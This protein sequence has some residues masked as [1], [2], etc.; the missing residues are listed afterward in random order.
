MYNLDVFGNDNFF[1]GEG[2]WLVH[3]A[4]YAAL[5][6]TLKSTGNPA[7][8]HPLN[9]DAAYRSMIPHSKGEAWL[10]VG[11]A[12]SGK[13][14]AHYNAHSSMESFWEQYRT[15]SLVGNLPT[16]RQYEIALA[17]SLRNAGLSPSEIKTAV[18]S[19]RNQRLSYGLSQSDDVPRLP[20][21]INQ[22]K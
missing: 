3:N 13:G 11:N 19:A 8:A 18:Q 12:F 4:S 5:C 2:Q 6:K 14:T 7:Q 17:R 22:S 20:G 16:N 9:Q 1:V 15:G 21:R 10:L